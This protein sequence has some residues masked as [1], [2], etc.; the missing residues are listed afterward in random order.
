MVT[1]NQLTAGK[2]SI[3]RIILFDF[4]FFY[5]I[6]RLFCTYYYIFFLY[7]DHIGNYSSRSNVH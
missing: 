4:R 3:P 6:N 1:V 2:Y 5:Y 7:C